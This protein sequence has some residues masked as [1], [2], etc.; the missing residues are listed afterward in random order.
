MPDRPPFA[1]DLRVSADKAKRKTGRRAVTGASESANRPCDFPGC[2]E[3]GV[4]RAPKSPDH[5]NEFFWFCR[6]HI[7][8]Y[9][10]KWNFFGTAT[11][12]EFQKLLEKD[13][14]WERETTPFSRKDDGRAWARLGVDDPMD[15]LGEKGTQ[16][17]GRI[18]TAT[19]KLPSTERKA[20]EILDA[21]DTWT[22]T[23]IRKQYKSLVKDLHPDMN[24]GDR[25]DE[26]RLQEVVWAWD[27]IKD[28]RYFKE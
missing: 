4:H 25:S 7:R 17:P 9:N 21:R 18:P 8:E 26:D 3:K 19:R 2:P 15:I 10:L 1:F 5:L 23:E 20:I 11:D 28:S 27:Q 14:L 22:K 24:A 6:D 13:R 12:E 16:N